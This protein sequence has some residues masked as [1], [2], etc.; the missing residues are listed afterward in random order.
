VNEDN[1]AA[2]SDPLGGLDAFGKFKVL[3]EIKYDFHLE[4]LSWVLVLF[5]LS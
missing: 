3:C 1:Q 2:M 4:D 5:Q